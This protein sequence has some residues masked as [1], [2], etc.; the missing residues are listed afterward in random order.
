MPHAE[1]QRTQS[2]IIVPMLQHGN[3]VQD[4]P[5]SSDLYL[6]LKSGHPVQVTR[7]EPGNDKR[8]SPRIDA[9][10][11][12]YPCFFRDDPWLIIIR[13]FTELLSYKIH[14]PLFF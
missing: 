5:A 11:V 3:A 9:E 14:P 10:C 13:V 2:I 6:K 4:A 7:L 12:I 1:T 8:Y